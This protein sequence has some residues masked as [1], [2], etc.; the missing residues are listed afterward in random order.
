MLKFEKSL[1]KDLTRQAIIMKNYDR[2]KWDKNDGHPAPDFLRQ[3]MKTKA[4]EKP[5]FMLNNINKPEKN[6]RLYFWW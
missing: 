6:F 2:I 1:I 4:I 5:N 3:G